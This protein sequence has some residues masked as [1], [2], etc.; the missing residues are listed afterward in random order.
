MTVGLLR[1]HNQSIPEIKTDYIFMVFFLV[2]VVPLTGLT[3]TGATTAAAVG[4]ATAGEAVG[5]TTT[6]A[7]GVAGATCVTV[8]GVRGWCV[9][10]TA[11]GTIPPPLP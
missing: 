1:L 3:T 4:A 2:G 5:V 9:L 6:G 8:P 10:A 7:V 11:V